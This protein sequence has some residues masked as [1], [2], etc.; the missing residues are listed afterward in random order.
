M[1]LNPLLPHIGLTLQ[2]GHHA[3]S[4]ILQKP[5]NLHSLFLFL[6]LPDKSTPNRDLL[7]SSPAD[8]SRLPPS[9]PGL[10]ALLVAQPTHNHSPNSSRRNFLKYKLNCFL[11]F[12]KLFRGS[13]LHEEETPHCL[14]RPTTG[15]DPCP[16]SPASVPALS[17]RSFHSSLLLFLTLDT[18]LSQDLCTCYSLF[19][20][21]TPLPTA[22]LF[23]LCHLSEMVVFQ[24][25]YD[26]Q[27]L[28]FVE[29][30]FS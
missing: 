10:L 1:N 19:E 26:A 12:L 16:P 7:L 6:L 4:Y 3:L 25:T 30:S 8:W 11:P 2:E 22:C 14:R 5:G 17:P 20:V 29:L 15:T 24:T 13:L 23:S 18:H 28:R 9:T 21:I 27:C